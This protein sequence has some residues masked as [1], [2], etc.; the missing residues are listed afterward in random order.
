MSKQDAFYPPKGKF[1]K[2]AAT[3]YSPKPFYFVQTSP[4]QEVRIPCWSF[5]P[6]LLAELM[7]KL[8]ADFPDQVSVLTKFKPESDEDSDW[9]RYHGLCSNRAVEHAIAKFRKFLL[10]DS[11]HQF[12]VRNPDTGEYF[13][14]DDYGILWLYPADKPREDVLTATG[15]ENKLQE[16][17][18]ERGCWKRRL[19]DSQQRMRE[20]VDFLLLEDVAVPEKQIDPEERPPC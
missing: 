17:I 13:A 10:Q 3:N 9:H 7:L 20:L 19:P 2:A 4:Q 14:L 6:E 11:S 8:L 16:L 15:F 12:L 5:D 18:Y 1:G